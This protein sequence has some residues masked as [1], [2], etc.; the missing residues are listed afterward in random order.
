MYV[1]V[2]G[3]LKKGYRN[4]HLLETAEFIC[5]AQTTDSV[6]RMLVF[7]SKAGGEYTYPAV[8][9]DGVGNITG[10]VYKI[11]DDILIKLDDLEDEGKR[12]LRRPVKL[13]CDID[14]E[15]Y[16]SIEFEKP[17]HNQNIKYD[18]KTKRYTYVE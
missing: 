15:F 9:N 2:Y 13:D 8:F 5:A 10:E 18:E 17:G 14:A 6:Y 1:F 12:Y 4:A 11:T 16:L 7:P 3:T